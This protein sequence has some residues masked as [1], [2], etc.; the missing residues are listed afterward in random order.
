MDGW[1]DGQI[2]INRL[3][4]AFSSASLKMSW[5]NHI[6][7]TIKK[8]IPFVAVLRRVNC[9]DTKC[10]KMIYHACIHSVLSY[11]LSIW[12]NASVVDMKRIERLQKK[13]LKIIHR[14]PIDTPSRQLYEITCTSNIA[15]LKKLESCKLMYKIKNNLMKI[16]SKP[17]KK[18]EVH[19]YHTR[20]A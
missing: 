19:S 6:D 14:L 20:Q 10:K 18:Q 9:M 1:M 7:N 12:S 8:L 2:K 11:L 16:N 5:E 3:A 17:I 13:S 4:F 15:I